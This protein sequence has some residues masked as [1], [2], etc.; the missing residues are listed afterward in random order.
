MKCLDDHEELTALGRLVA[1]IPV[2]PSLAKMLI[3]GTLFQQGD[4]MCI[5]AASD[6]IQADV[7]T[8]GVDLK[9]L[10]HRQRSFAGNR[11]SDHVALISAFYAYEQVKL[12][13][14]FP[15]AEFNFCEAQSLSLSSLRVLHDARCQLR[16]ILIGF[17]FPESALAP[18][19]ISADQFK[20]VH[21]L[22]NL[23]L[24]SYLSLKH[25]PFHSI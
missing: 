13:Q 12:E 21:L 19:V 15:D 9:R 5:L 17:G 18:K 24:I 14:Q 22:A 10:T 8:M 25:K 2:E 11:Q 6:S 20:C 1:R 7:F 16:D 23:V 4:A 3:V